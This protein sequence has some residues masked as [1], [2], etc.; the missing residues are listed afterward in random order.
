MSSLLIKITKQTSER[1]RG[2]SKAC[3]QE[4]SRPVL[5]RVSR[6]LRHDNSDF[7]KTVSQEEF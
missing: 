2:L 1:D 7:V 6:N 5:R 4:G 3:L